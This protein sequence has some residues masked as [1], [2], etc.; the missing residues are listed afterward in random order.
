MISETPAVSRSKSYARMPKHIG[1]IPDGN[2]RWADQRSLPRGR[3]YLPGV[4]AAFR[5]LAEIKSM[6]IEEVSVYGFTKEN[7]HR[8]S[9]QRIAF[10]EACV[11]AV[12][13]L[14]F[15]NAELRVIGDSNT[16]MFPSEL[17]P[18]VDRK[19]LGTGGIKI[20]LLINYSWKWD[21]DVLRETGRLGSYDVS[22]IDLIVRWGGRSRLSGFLPIQ[23]AYSDICVLEN[24]WPDSMGDDIHKALEWYQW[25]DPTRGG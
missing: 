7:V 1:I 18:Y 11:E 3:G 24:L 14:S 13:R 6:N 15:M 5:I 4:D 23:S 20:N 2:R 22:P 9:E 8:P 12:R 21:V 19:I 16:P 17:M 25:Q 10:Q